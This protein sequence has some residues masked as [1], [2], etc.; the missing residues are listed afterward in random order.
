MKSRQFYILILLAGYL[1]LSWLNNAFILTEEVFYA[2]LGEQI[3]FEKINSIFLMKK[4]LEWLSYLFIPI[5]L[6]LKLLTISIVLYSGILLSGLKIRFSRILQLVIKAEFVFLL[7]GL[8]KFLWV[9]LHHSEISFTSIAFFQP[10]SLINF[11][12]PNDQLTYLVYPLQIIN[13]F[14]LAYC[15]LLALLLKAL[16]SVSFRKSIDL[17]LNTYGVGLLVWVVFVVFISLNYS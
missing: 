10:L 17:V 6:V 7:M 1:L 8:M 2:S 15:F 13:L 5:S 4:D 11:F 14:E 12:S 16:L 9:Y 3:T